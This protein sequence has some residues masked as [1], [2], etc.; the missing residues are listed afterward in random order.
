MDDLR[1][2]WIRDRVYEALD[3]NKVD[4][5]NEFL[6]RDEQAAESQLAQYLNENPHEGKTSLIFY[7]V[8]VEED[9]EVEIEVGEL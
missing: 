1:I 5:F 7:K 6:E 9:R 4:V 3:I 8:I 2:E